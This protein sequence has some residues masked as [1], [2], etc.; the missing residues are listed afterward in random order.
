MTMMEVL[1]VMGVL[2]IF[3]YAV[4]SMSSRS[5]LA[6]NVGVEQKNIHEIGDRAF[7]IRG[8]TGSYEGVT[9]AVAIEEEIIPPRLVQS[10]PNTRFKQARHSWGGLITVEPVAISGIN[11]SGLSIVYNDVPQKACTR[12]GSA[13]GRSMW[14]VRVNDI[15][16]LTNPLPNDPDTLV[17]DVPALAYAC[18]RQGGGGSIPVSKS[19]RAGGVTMRFIRNDN[20]VGQRFVATDLELPT[21]G[22]GA[23]VPAPGGPMPPSAPGMGPIVPPGPMP[24]MPPMPDTPVAPPPPGGFS[25]PEMLLPC[26]IPSPPDVITIHQACK[27][28]LETR[29]LESR[30][31]CPGR[32]GPI[33]W[34]DWTVVTPCGEGGD[35]L[36]PP[37]TPP[38][39]S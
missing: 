5:T 26:T 20:V 11:N 4:Y 3:G 8:S 35:P 15:E 24:P 28:P 33:L 16:V 7:S 17:L 13:A 12:M 31:Y 34:T 29:V 10:R 14:S 39:G 27:N 30:A 1:L 21:P 22:D 2:A 36:P 9:T 23:H 38:V 32:G 25:N 19:N 6:K 18:N 37:G